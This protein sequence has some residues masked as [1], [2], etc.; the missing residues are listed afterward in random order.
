MVIAEKGTKKGN[1]SLFL[2][3][4]NWFPLSYFQT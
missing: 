2:I 1:N 4:G 3:Q